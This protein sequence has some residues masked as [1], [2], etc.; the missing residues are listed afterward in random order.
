MKAFTLILITAILFELVA[1]GL[2]LRHQAAM[3][4]P[5]LPKEH[6]ADATITPQLEKLADAAQSGNS[7]DWKRLGG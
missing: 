7:E 2:Y 5:L 4:I 3:T 1:A 6:L